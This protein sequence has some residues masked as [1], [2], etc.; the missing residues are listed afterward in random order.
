MSDINWDE[1]TVLRKNINSKKNKEESKNKAIRSGNYSTVKKNKDTSGAKMY[2]L[3]NE[4]IG[5]ISKIDIKL[6]LIIKKARNNLNIPQEQLAKN[7]SIKKNIRRIKA[8][9]T[10]KFYQK[11]KDF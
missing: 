10:T 9:K 1:F 4:E 2:K 6:G 5:T 3:D 7:L 8:V 11:W